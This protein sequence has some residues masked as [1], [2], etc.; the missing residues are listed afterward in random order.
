M[1]VLNCVYNYN[2]LSPL[3]YLSLRS[4]ATIKGPPDAPF[5]YNCHTCVLMFGGTDPHSQLRSEGPGSH[6]LYL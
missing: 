1:Y 4:V 3:P 2:I 5:R 6:C